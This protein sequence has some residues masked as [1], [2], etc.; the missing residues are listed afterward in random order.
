MK[1][2]RRSGYEDFRVSS[3]IEPVEHPSGKVRISRM[4]V[5]LLDAAQSSYHRGGR[6]RPGPL[7]QLHI[8]TTMMMSDGYHEYIQ[9]LSAIHNA[10]GHVLV[11]GLGLGCYVK[12]ILAKPNVERVTVV[13]LLPE[14]IE[15]VAPYYTSDPRVEIIHDD[16]F[17]RAKSWPRGSRWDCVWHDL[18]P[19]QLE[20]Y[21]PQMAALKRSYARRCGWQG[22]WAQEEIRADRRREREFLG[23]LGVPP[24]TEVNRGSIPGWA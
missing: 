8:G 21:L 6:V 16:A 12:A 20:A 23:R 24:G 17:R 13:E 5:S 11:N 2:M 10:H 22:C 7:T 1:T 4:E 15:L 9:H 3:L 19:S 18:W 14:V